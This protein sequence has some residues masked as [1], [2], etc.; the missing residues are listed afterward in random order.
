MIRFVRTLCSLNYIGLLQDIDAPGVGHSL[1]KKTTQKK[2]LLLV[3]STY[4]TDTYE[5]HSPRFLS[6]SLYSAPSL[7]V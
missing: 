6:K 2:N 5:K 7:H 3:S 4:L 1:F